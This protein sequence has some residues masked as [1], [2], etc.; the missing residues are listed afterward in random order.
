MNSRT[1]RRLRRI[2]HGLGH[3]R[4]RLEHAQSAEAPAIRHRIVR[5]QCPDL[6][7]RRDAGARIAVV[8]RAQQTR[9][10]RCQVL[11]GTVA[12]GHDGPQV[13][14]TER[15]DRGSRNPARDNCRLLDRDRPV[16]E[17]DDEPSF[18]LAHLIAHDVWLHGLRPRRLDRRCPRRQVHR[19]ESPNRPGDA[20][21][22]DGKVSCS[23]PANRLPFVVEHGHVELNEL[24]AGAKLRQFVLVLSRETGGGGQRERHHAESAHTHTYSLIGRKSWQAWPV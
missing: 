24:D 9:A 2:L 3:A 11:D 22:E 23:Q 8:D 4:D 20:F 21:L 19:R 14:G 13:A 15:V 16:H 1:L 12:G 6:L 10:I 18:L 5:R 17:D 7:F